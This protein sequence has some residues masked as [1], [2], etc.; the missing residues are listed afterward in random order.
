MGARTFNQSLSELNAKPKQFANYFLHSIKNDYIQ[1]ENC[2]SSLGARVAYKN[3]IISR[4]RQDENGKEM[5]QNVQR[6][7]GVCRASV[8]AH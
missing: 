7:R 3:S 2:N 5:Y 8:F 1:R 4:R 6:T